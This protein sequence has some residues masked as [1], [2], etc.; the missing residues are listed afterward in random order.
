MQINPDISALAPLLVPSAGAPKE[1]LTVRDEGDRTIV[2]I[3]YSSLDIIQTCPRKAQ[4]VLSRGLRSLVEPASLAYGTAIH[5]A[6]EVFYSHPS[7]VRTMPVNFSKHAELIPAGVEPPEQH[8]LYD[9]VKAFCSAGA[10][11]AALPEA[12]QRS[13]S[14]G[15][16]T[17][18]HYFDTYLKDEYVVYCDDKGPVTE[19]KFHLELGELSPGVTVVLI[20]QIDV[21]LQ[22]ERTGVV[23]P[24]DHKT[25]SM[26][27]NEFFTRC[28]PNHQYTGYLL[29]ARSVLGIDTDSF[30]VNG[31]EVKK[32]PMKGMMPKLTRQITKRSA[33]DIEEFYDV[34]SEAVSNYLNWE[35]QDVWP[36][37]PVQSCASYGGCTF[38]DVCSSPQSLR[39]DIIKAKFNTGGHRARTL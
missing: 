18:T 28:K 17:L 30:L 39:E 15:I 37:G 2:Y 13:L 38:I 1:M 4:Y 8:F 10:G 9:A 11:L 23:L 21:A 24:A 34:V 19:R 14:T 5:K 32:R 6:L 29:G 16:W 22:H 12:D 20:G 27:G 7:R 35:A 3:N 33:E 31:I 36:L 25:T 26:M